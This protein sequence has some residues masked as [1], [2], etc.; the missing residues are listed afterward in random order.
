MKHK[1]LL[2]GFLIF[3]VILIG[4]SFFGFSNLNWFN[5]KHLFKT[6]D[7]YLSAVNLAVVNVDKA[8]SL[9]SESGEMQG[10]CF[11]VVAETVAGEDF[12]G[13]SD[14]CERIIDIHWKGECFFVIAKSLFHKNFSLAY[15]TCKRSE[16]FQ[17]GCY[18]ALGIFLAESFDNASFVISACNEFPVEYRG[19]CFNGLGMVVGERF[20]NDTP[21]AVFVCNEVPVEFRK[22]CFVGMGR[23][24]VGNKRF[25]DRGFNSNISSAIFA[26][27]EAPV[28]FKRA[29]FF[30]LNLIIVNE[31]F[32]GDIT[33]SIPACNEFPVEYRGD[34]FYTLGQAVGR[35]F[36]NDI[37]SAVFACNGAPIEYSSH[38]F[39]GLSK[40]Y[41]GL[42]KN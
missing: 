42:N 13:G 33:M 36:S 7:S 41:K 35:R 26:C 14:V 38:C 23:G 5:N 15:E 10:E 22:D 18:G 27:N 12:K 34:C 39:E 16:T 17:P 24:F 20:N 9:C 37:S 1:K 6:Y 3:L 11:V 4:I 32:G 2:L 21:S 28:E 8:L 40:F 19:D 30:G 31:H 29:C 25:F